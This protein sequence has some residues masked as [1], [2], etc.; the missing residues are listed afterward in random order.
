MSKGNKACPGRSGAR[1]AS[2]NAALGTSLSFLL[3]RLLL[4]LRFQPNLSWR[5]SGHLTEPVCKRCPLPTCPYELPRGLPDTFL[6]WLFRQAA[7]C[8]PLPCQRQRPRSTAQ[9]LLY[10]A[11]ALAGVR[12]RSTSC[13]QAPRSPFATTS[14]QAAPPLHLLTYGTTCRYLEKVTGL[15]P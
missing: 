13:R 4:Y 1:T 8:W 9:I 3:H 10:R 14:R 6:V 11:R 12:T 7:Y 15:A 5:V 2:G